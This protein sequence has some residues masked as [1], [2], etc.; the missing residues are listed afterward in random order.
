[1]S[2]ESEFYYTLSESYLIMFITCNVVTIIA[3]SVLI[4][5]KAPIYAYVPMLFGYIIAMPDCYMKIQSYKRLARA[6][7]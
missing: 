7:S 4:Y 6:Y 2:K 1:M 5:V 3:G